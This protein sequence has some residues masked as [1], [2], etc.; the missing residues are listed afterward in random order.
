MSKAIAFA[1]VALVVW[2]ATL[3]LAPQMPRCPEDAVLVG[4]G[5]FSNGTWQGYECGP[6]LDDFR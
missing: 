3:T 1:L 6:A 2:V 5:D 4:V